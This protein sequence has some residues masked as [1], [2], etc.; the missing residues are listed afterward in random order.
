RGLETLQDLVLACVG[1]QQAGPVDVPCRRSVAEMEKLAEVDAY[2]LAPPSRAICP[3]H[4][5]ELRADEHELKERG[6][7]EDAGDGEVAGNL[8]EQAF[9]HPL[10]QIEACAEHD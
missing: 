5:V 9:S 2:Q 8:L 3:R 10:A 7:L 1:D 4:R 6:A